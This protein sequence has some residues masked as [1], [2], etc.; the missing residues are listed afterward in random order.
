MRENTTGGNIILI[1]MPGTGKTTVG[2]LLADALSYGF[3]DTDQFIT[4]RTGK[5]PRQIVESEGRERFLE[6]Q[7]EAVEALDCENCVISTGGGLVHSHVA[8]TR[9]KAMGIVIFLNTG[10][11]I[12]EER[13]DA[14]R[15]LVRAGGSLRELYDERIPLYNKYADAVVSCDNTEPQLLCKKILELAGKP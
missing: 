7:D 1:G 15:K 12:I 14:S 3:V 5:T 11:E 13:M 2:K 10:Y 8:M 9:L 6:I 4:G